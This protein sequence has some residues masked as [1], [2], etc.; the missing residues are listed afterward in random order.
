MYFAFMKYKTTVKQEALAV[1]QS[2]N[3]SDAN[4]E[5]ELCKNYQDA[6]HAHFDVS[7]SESSFREYAIRR[8]VFLHFIKKINLKTELSVLN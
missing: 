6:Y 1:Y 4:L 3:L 5:G 7:R 8:D 2:L